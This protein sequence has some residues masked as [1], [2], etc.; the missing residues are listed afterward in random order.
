MT[1]I[2][3]IYKYI[4]SFAPFK[5]AEKWDNC[6]ILIGNHKR[7]VK[8]AL[9]CL[10]VT[11]NAINQAVYIG[12]DLII[13]HHPVIFEPLKSIDSDSSVYNLIKN[14]IAVICTHTNL[15]ASQYGS[16]AM[17]S[18]LLNIDKSDFI[19]KIDDGFGIGR[20]GVLS[21]I[22]TGND[23]AGFV[24]SAFGTRFVRYLNGDRDIKTFAFCCGGGA[25]YIEA[26][27]KSGADA[28]ITSDIKHSYWIE[29][30]MLGITLVEVS[31]Y[32]MEKTCIKPLCDKLQKG[33]PYIE[34]V[35]FIDNNDFTNIL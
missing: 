23:F 33:F 13:S 24:K 32:D 22:K 10:D 4:D 25:S 2:I 17:A 27:V 15:D 8:K 30:K 20:V 11:K 1:T 5:F 12:A 28:F 6:G 31:H 16:D 9:V 7:E 35:P 21:E 3:D 29:A 34:F 18:K 19:V 26:A 14:N